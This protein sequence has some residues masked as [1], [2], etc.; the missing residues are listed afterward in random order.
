MVEAAPAP[1][2]DDRTRTVVVVAV[3]VLAVPAGW[4]VLRRR[5]PEPRSAAS[6]AEG[7]ELGR[8]DERARL[9]R[10]AAEPTARVIPFPAPGSK[11]PPAV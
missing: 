10:E 8:L 2:T 3:I 9:R 6:F 5:R 1:P 7:Y 11:R 4:A